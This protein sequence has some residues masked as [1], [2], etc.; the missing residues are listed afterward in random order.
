MKVINFTLYI[1]LFLYS[2]SLAQSDKSSTEEPMTAKKWRA[3]IQYLIEQL[4][5]RHPN[6]YHKISKD[7]L[8]REFAAL[9]ARLESLAQ[10]E[11]PI[12]LAKIV[13]QIGDMHTSVRQEP[14]FYS[15]LEYY[16]FGDDLYIIGADSQYVELAGVRVTQIGNTPVNDALDSLLTVYPVE[17]LYGGKSNVA[18]LAI[19]TELFSAMRIID[20]PRKVPLTY[21][22]PAG[23]KS[24][25]VVSTTERPNIDLFVRANRNSQNDT[26]FWMD[27]RNSNYWFEYIA[28]TSTLYAQF[29]FVRNNEEGESVADFFERLYQWAKTNDF[30]RFVLDLRKNGGGGDQ[31]FQ[32]SIKRLVSEPLNRPGKF[33]TIIGRDVASAAQHLV[34]DL[35]YLTNTIFVGEPTGQN[36]QFYSDSRYFLLPESGLGVRTCL[37]WMQNSV[38]SPFE[39]RDA[40][41][42][43][44][45]AE[46][47][48]E[49]YSDNIDPSLEAIY[50]YEYQEPLTKRMETAIRA[51]ELTSLADM[52][53]KFVNDPANKYINTKN[54][55]N[56]LGY[57]LDWNDATDAVK[58]LF[59]LNIQAHPNSANCHDS[60]GELLLSIGD[61]TQAI[62]EYKQ[63]LILD[64]EGRIGANAKKILAELVD[65]K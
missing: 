61:T 12:A 35:E 6:L 10:Y 25:I 14:K 13:A 52:H 20:D 27:S 4:P 28:E 8:Y 39:K 21:E 24:I 3:D 41:Y 19:R 22:T 64:S 26:P 38:P 54:A 63:A 45:A 32:S 30:D 7:K 23:V 50:A 42:P 62:V 46:P 51:G 18:A 11:I 40:L 31:L 43:I 53:W 29:N 56:T 16:V 60:Y 9:D 49:S 33:F 1:S 58:I 37:G 59:K 48:I 17:N 5:K 34:N 47:T 57:S 2:V 55:L 36:V 65:F 15:P 44:I